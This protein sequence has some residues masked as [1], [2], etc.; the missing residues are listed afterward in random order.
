MCLSREWPD[1][2]VSGTVALLQDVG[3]TFGPSKMDLEAWED[4]VMWQDRATCTV[5]MRNCLRR[6][7]VQAECESPKR[8]GSFSI[9]LIDSSP[10]DNSPLFYSARASIRKRGLLSNVRPSPSGCGS[11]KPSGSRSARGVTVPVS[12]RPP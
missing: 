4:V 11:S 9:K 10:I 12:C 1:G 5:S 7:H 2:G 3:A 6:R 8:A